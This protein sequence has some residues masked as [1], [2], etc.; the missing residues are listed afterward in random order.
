MSSKFQNC[1]MLN[2]VK[3]LGSKHV[4][5]Q[6]NEILRFAQNDTGPRRQDGGL[7]MHPQ[8]TILSRLLPATP[9]RCSG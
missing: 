4:R 7:G 1:V 6:A 5:S 2:E 3:H 9:A 8:P